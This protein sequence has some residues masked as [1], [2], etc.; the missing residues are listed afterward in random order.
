MLQNVSYCPILYA[1]VAEIKALLNLPEASKN[2]ILPI[3]VARPWPN[4]NSLELT[5]EKIT[6]AMGNRR[7]G[8][9]LDL[10]RYHSESTRPA[11]TEFDLLFD[12]HN[13][14]ENYY[15]T[16]ERLPFAIPV[17]R[18][19]GGEAPFLE[20]QINQITRLD[21]GGIL[22]VQYGSIAHPI[23]LVRTV[24]EA[25][26]D[27]VVFIDMGWSP[28]ILSRQMWAS[29]IIQEISNIRREPEIAVCG[30]S[31]PESFSHISGKG[32]ID[33]NER[34]VFAS[35]V[36]QHNEAT[37]VYGDWGSTR[38]P[39]TEN[40]PMSNIP[41]RIDLPTLNQWIFFRE[42]DGESYPELARRTMTDD[43]WPNHLN[44]WG[45]YTIRCTADGLPGA[46]RSPG[47][48]A[49]SRINIHLHTQAQFGEEEPIN[50][51]DV[52]FTD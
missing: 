42:N 28:D 41:I 17:L 35:L 21:R 15:R 52:P 25:N 30:S 38:P 23:S 31:F 6:E 11:A 13:G 12:S 37:L 45:T 5:W 16:L 27:I 36:R 1:R 9:D 4:A 29:N 19:Q 44:I 43:L 18:L 8:V 34:T 51:G 49:A 40:H 14:F 48:A 39:A 22:R 50:D 24:L 10:A 26:T 7:F 20:E 47:T 32:S 3:L 2:R 46:I 33:V